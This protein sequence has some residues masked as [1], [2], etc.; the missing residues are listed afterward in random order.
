MRVFIISSPDRKL[1]LLYLANDI[2]QESRRRGNEFI[3]EFQNVIE[4]AII[5]TW[6]SNPESIQMKVMRLL[7]IWEERLVFPAAFIQNI[8]ENVRNSKSNKAVKNTNEPPFQKVPSP[9]PP[10]DDNSD[11]E[12][13]KTGELESE[14]IRKHFNIY[15]P[16]QVEL[17]QNNITKI[18]EHFNE[19]ITKQSELTDI[20]ETAKEIAPFCIEFTP[21]Q[22]DEIRR[23]EMDS[24]H[25]FK[26]Q[27][28]LNETA[29]QDYKAQLQND[30]NVSKTLNELLNHFLTHLK[31]HSTSQH[32]T[33]NLLNQLLMSTKT[34]QQKLEQ[35]IGQF[36]VE[37]QSGSLTLS[38]PNMK[39]SEETQSP[40][41]QMKRT[42]HDIGNPNILVNFND[43]KRRKKSDDSEDK[44]DHQDIY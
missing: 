29:I 5:S 15:S 42:Q 22:L 32:K 1:Q 14:S 40:T 9:L 34:L 13:D 18:I 17:Q 3:D 35:R 12:G 31:T 37:K 33:L 36:D 25:S 39:Q 26:S 23:G 20:E 44:N 27:L 24:L 16:S 8:K 10:T 19:W 7:D 2:L 28:E 43:Y 6:N 11:G 4:D 30:H 21:G 41:T 38:P